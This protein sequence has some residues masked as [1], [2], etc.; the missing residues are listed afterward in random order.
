VT[1]GGES[2][3][4]TDLGEDPRSGPHAD[5]RDAEQDR[6]LRVARG[7]RVD[8]TGELLAGGREPGELDSGVADHSAGRRLGWDGHGLSVEGGE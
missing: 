5:S 7:D 1:G 4:V 8:L 6:R 3:D 2:G